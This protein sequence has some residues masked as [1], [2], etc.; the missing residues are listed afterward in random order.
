MRY[1]YETSDK[2]C[3]SRIVLDIEDGTVTKVRFVGGCA[4]NTQGVARLV[5]G[6]APKEVIRRLKDVQCGSRGSSCPAEL[7]QALEAALAAAQNKG[8]AAKDGA[9]EKPAEVRAEQQG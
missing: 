4:G 9:A 8:G 7:A 2:V 3:S 1:E 6:M 5:E